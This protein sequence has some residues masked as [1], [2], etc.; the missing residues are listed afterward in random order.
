VDT[1][2]LDTATIWDWT[3]DQLARGW[4]SGLIS[5]L[6]PEF[7]DELAAREARDGEEE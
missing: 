2:D 1:S 4:T 5:D 7:W 6:P 3:D